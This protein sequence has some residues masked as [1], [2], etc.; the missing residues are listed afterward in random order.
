[1]PRK[2]SRPCREPGCPN[3][4]EPGK[5]Y[6]KKHNKENWKYDHD[7]T[8]AERGYTYQWQ[9]ARRAYLHAHPLC[10]ECLRHGRYTEATVVDH[11]VPHRGD[12]TLFWDESNWQSLCKQHHDEKTGKEDTRM[13]YEYRFQPKG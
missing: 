2:P 3:L 7:K 5:L 6:C 12:R 11:I 8:A 9:Q 4:A 10:A 1:M 13:R